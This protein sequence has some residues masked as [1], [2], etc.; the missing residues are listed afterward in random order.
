[1]AIFTAHT[2]SAKLKSYF[3]TGDV[4][5]QAEFIDLIDSFAV[6]SGTLPY[7]SGSGTGTGSF[8]NLIITGSVES[9]L[10][11]SKNNK[12]DLGSGNFLWKNAFINHLSGSGEAGEANLTASLNIIPG[13]DNTYSLGMAGREWKDLY[14]DGTWRCTNRWYSNSR[15]K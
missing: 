4:P 5:T 3:E 2:G 14:I 12:Y 11:P 6:Y 13:A 10:F 9:S 1:M 7:I 8:G 15:C